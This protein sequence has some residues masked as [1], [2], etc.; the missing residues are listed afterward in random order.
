[1]TYTAQEAN[2]IGQTIW[3]QIP[4]M[5]KPTI[6]YELGRLSASLR[7]YREKLR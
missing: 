1:M 3:Q 7:S 4:V 5:V 2:E 6:T